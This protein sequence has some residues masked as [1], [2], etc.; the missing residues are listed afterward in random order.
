MRHYT[1]RERKACPQ[2]AAPFARDAANPLAPVPA[3]ADLQPHEEKFHKALDT[4]V[5][6]AIKS[7]C[8]SYCAGGKTIR[9]GP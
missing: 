3:N 4:T 2:P 9:D 8:T 5:G 6:C 1:S 7:T